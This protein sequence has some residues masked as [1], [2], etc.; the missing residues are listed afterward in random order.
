MSEEEKELRGRRQGEQPKGTVTD[1]GKDAL[2][3][4]EALGI[5][6]S[7]M[8]KLAAKLILGEGISG[9]LFGREKN[10]KKSAFEKSLA[11]I[12]ELMIPIMVFYLIYT[13]FR[14]WCAFQGVI[15]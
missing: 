5:K 11:A 6:K 7:D 2:S 1:I 14:A 12:K 9:F 15:I 3:L 8:G 10:V 13:F 4:A